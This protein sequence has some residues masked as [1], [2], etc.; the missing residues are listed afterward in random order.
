MSGLMSR[1]RAGQRA[2]PQSAAQQGLVLFARADP[3]AAMPPVHFEGWSPASPPAP[4]AVFDRAEEVFGPVGALVANAGA[5]RVASLARRQDRSRR[6]PLPGLGPAPPPDHLSD[7]AFSNP[8]GKVYCNLTITG[9]S[10]FVAVFI[11][12][13]E[14]HLISLDPGRRRRRQSGPDVT[15]G[16][17]SGRCP[18]SVPPWS[19]RRGSA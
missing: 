10:V 16:R 6:R 11:G 5:S 13:T 18:R 2:P 14:P 9:L 19:R 15:A 1:G 8:V 12:A 17:S 3:P 4:F 7:W